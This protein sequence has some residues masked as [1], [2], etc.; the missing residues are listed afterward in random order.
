[1]LGVAA[2]RG[3]VQAAALAASHLAGRHA[4]LQQTVADML[5]HRRRQ[6]RQDSLRQGGDVSGQGQGL[7]GGDWALPGG[8]GGSMGPDDGQGYGQGMGGAG[9]FGGGTGTGTEAGMGAIGA[10]ARGVI[11]GKGGSSMADVSRL[12]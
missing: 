2:Q 12:L 8:L 4:L 5:M 7:H 1:V 10:S 9:G 3:D 6:Y 11:T